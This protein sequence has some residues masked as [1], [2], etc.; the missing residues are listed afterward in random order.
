M[1]TRRDLLQLGVTG[2]TLAVASTTGAPITVA[3]ASTREFPTRAVRLVE[4]F[5]LGGGPDLTA[6]AL[7]RELSRIWDVPVNVDNDPGA[8]STL[9]P[10]LV[11]A[12]PPDGHTLLVSTSAQAYSATVAQDLPYDPLK[13]FTPVC[14]LSSQAYVFVTGAKTG[15]KSVHDLIS[16]AEQGQSAITFAS[17]GIGT[18]THIGGIELSKAAGLHARHVPS[19]PGEAIT[20]VL[21]AMSAGRAHYMLAPIPTA[22]PAIRGGSLIALGVS[23][24]RRSS[25]V[26]EIPAVAEV[27][28]AKFDFPI[29]YAVWA[30]AATPANVVRSLA[31]D[32]QSVSTS[33]S[34]RTWL[35]GHGA[36]PMQMSQREFARFVINES[37]RALQTIES[38][39]IGK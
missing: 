19:L 2:L 5:G 34:M 37:R 13:D 17:T 25:L 39:E 6:R 35:Q 23:T 38:R 1:S 29:W 24:S 30:P 16:L 26:P 9:G 36:E 8:G 12:S 14:P 7:A 32:I 33:S 20:D 31:A 18:G 22:L 4:P 27:G 10:K 15:I 28:V 3:K 21:A 11:A